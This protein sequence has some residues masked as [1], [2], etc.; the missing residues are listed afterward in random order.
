MSIVVYCFVLFVSS[1]F[2][3]H[4][5][6][7]LQLHIQAALFLCAYVCQCDR[8]VNPLFTQMKPVLCGWGL[9]LIYSFCMA[10]NVF[11]SKYVWSR[12]AILFMKCHIFMSLLNAKNK[13]KPCLYFFILRHQNP[14]NSIS[15]TEI[16]SKAPVNNLTQ[17]LLKCLQNVSVI[18]NKLISSGVFF[19]ILNQLTHQIY[20]NSCMSMLVFSF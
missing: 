16:N 13:E 19:F 7:F 1:S 8:Q 4:S 9:L 2:I 11:C 5:C 15:I 14:A 10:W 18:F 17:A 3:L 12:C 6:R 20:S